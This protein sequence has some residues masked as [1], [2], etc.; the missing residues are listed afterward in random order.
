MQTLRKRCCNAI[1]ATSSCYHFLGFL[2]IDPSTGHPVMTPTTTTSFITPSLRKTGRLRRL[3]SISL[4]SIP[5]Q[6]G[7]QGFHVKFWPL[8]LD[9]EIL[10]RS[11]RRFE[12]IKPFATWDGSVPKQLRGSLPWDTPGFLGNPISAATCT[13]KCR[14]VCQKEASKF[15]PWS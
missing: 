4:W 12:K 13:G 8:K 15:C 9:Q 3:A 5:S 2:S 6:S 14:W 11:E 7:P 10:A 1:I